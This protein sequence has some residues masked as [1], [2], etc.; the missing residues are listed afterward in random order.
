ML[1]SARVRLTPS[2][3]MVSFSSRGGR[4]PVGY[5]DPFEDT[6]SFVIEA[7][8]YAGDGQ[9]ELWVLWF[10]LDFLAELRYIDMQTMYPGMRL[11]APDL[12][13]QYL[14]R[15]N[16]A[17]VD[18]EHLEQIEFG[19]GQSNLLPGELDPPHGKIDGER[20]NLEAWFG[21]MRRLDDTAQGDAHPRQHF[22][23]AEGLGDVV[24]SSQVERLHLIA[25]GILG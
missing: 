8:A 13:E 24:I 4:E 25:L 17:T 2:N 7:I 10:W 19:R 23:D 22:V 5:L 3:P 15:E 12:F 1:K 6:G 16:L 9:D 11:L 14:A 21:T 20:T 18:N